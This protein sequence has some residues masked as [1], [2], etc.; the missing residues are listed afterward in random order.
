MNNDLHNENNLNNENNCVQNDSG[1]NGTEHT[2]DIPEKPTEPAASIPPAGASATDTP[3]GPAATATEKPE[4]TAEETPAPAPVTNSHVYTSY[5]PAPM[6][7]EE[8]PKKKP[9]KS[10]SISKGALAIFCICTLLLSCASGFLG[11]YFATA[12]ESAPLTDAPN[13]GTPQNPTV[14]YQSAAN[15]Q[16]GMSADNGTS[17]YYNAADLVHACVVEITTEHLVNSYFQYV[18]Q[19]AGSGVIIS[20]DGYIVTNNH[21]IA[22]TDNGNTLANSITVRMT[23][24]AEY[25]AT[26][27][28]T[29]ADSDI[30]VLKIEADN[31]PAAV[32][33]DSDKLAVGEEVL[34]VG[35]PLG[36]LGGTVTNGIISAL[37]REI[38]VDGTTMN[39]LQ[40][41]AAI[42]PGNSGGGLFNMAGELI[43]IVNAKSSGTGIEGLGFAI[44]V[45][46]AVLI[47]EQLM[48]QG[49]VSGKP[50]LG[51]SLY[52][53]TTPTQAL[54]YNLRHLGVYVIAVE[55]GTN[56][57]VFKQ[58]D[59]IIAVDGL[60]I[61]TSDDV[62][63]I[64]KTFSVGDTI[65]VT[66]Y[67]SGK[68]LEVY[69]TAYEKIPTT[70]QSVQFGE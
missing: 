7:K 8:P 52:D 22:D 66:I 61:S 63:S 67:R 32:I 43:G 6:P 42:N 2:A 5:N 36:E 24:G 29:D 1:I 9:K 33:G 53:I 11:A 21:V 23:D 26:V 34:A 65:K 31:L 57:D 4:P 12:G 58:G 38:N 39:L 59:R 19:G 46:D 47:A 10:D 16:S 17:Q 64:V 14:I 48:T 13:P 49:Y 56:D 44:P 35:N 30:A 55:E 28:G 45:N 25:E 60:E 54:Y 68:M 50:Y 40:T 41:N 18:T 27:I 20:A 37:D 62:A 3:E 15:P 70:S 69:A 51:L